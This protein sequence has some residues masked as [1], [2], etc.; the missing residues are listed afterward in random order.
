MSVVESGVLSSKGAHI[1]KKQTDRHKTGRVSFGEL[2]SLLRKGTTGLLPSRDADA[3]SKALL[4][5]PGPTV[6]EQ[7]DHLSSHQQQPRILTG[8]RSAFNKHAS[9]P[10][11]HQSESPADAT[12]ETDGEV[13]VSSADPTSL[14][15]RRL[16][17]EQAT[18]AWTDLAPIATEVLTSAGLDPVDVEKAVK[19]LPHTAPTDEQQTL[20]FEQW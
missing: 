15:A 10:L 1:V 3:L 5:D 12:T 9:T 17:A 7:F 6:Q 19:Q 13:D 4:V 2:A 14:T 20:D 8:L 18:V 11:A 16:A